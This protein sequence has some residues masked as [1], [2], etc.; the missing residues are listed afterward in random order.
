MS[1]EER[2]Q[3]IAVYSL[4]LVALFT[5]VPA[6]VGVILAYIFREDAGPVAQSHFEHQ[7]GLFWRAVFGNVIN[8][9]IFAVG[10]ALTSTV[11]FSIIGI[12]LMIVSG[13]VFIWL[14]LMLLTRSIRGISR[15][16]RGEGYPVPAGWGL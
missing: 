13:I 14:W 6:L 11:I 12:P 9:I 3:G 4:Y 7:I 15:L 2:W 16:N 8:G 10:V 5:G 1:D